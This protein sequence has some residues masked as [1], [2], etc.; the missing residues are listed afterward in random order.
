MLL[1]HQNVEQELPVISCV[2]WWLLKKKK[3]V[4]KQGYSVPP[5]L[6][7]GESERIG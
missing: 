7:V 6:L 4:E 3:K 1:G 5:V 2:L